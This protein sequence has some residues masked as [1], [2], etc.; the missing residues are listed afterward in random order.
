MFRIITSSVP[1]ASFVFQTEKKLEFTNYTRHVEGTT[2]F[3]LFLVYLE[4]HGSRKHL[5]PYSDPQLVYVYTMSVGVLVFP[6]VFCECTYR[7]RTCVRV[8]VDGCK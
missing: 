5:P 7:V 6:S 4:P 1:R 3:L 2:K 8:D